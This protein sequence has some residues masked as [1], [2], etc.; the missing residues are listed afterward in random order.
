[1][2]NFGRWFTATK[3]WGLTLNGPYYY[4][5][6][7]MNRPPHRR[8]WTM[9]HDKY[10]NVDTRRH[11]T[12]LS[13][14]QS[15]RRGLVGTAVTTIIWTSVIWLS[16]RSVNPYD[17]MF[18]PSVFFL[19]MMIVL[20]SSINWCWNFRCWSFTT[21]CRP[22][23]S[24]LGWRSSEIKAS[25]NHFFVIKLF[26]NQV[27][28]H[29]VFFLF[30][31]SNRKRGKWSLPLFWQVPPTPLKR[32]ERHRRSQTV[33][34]VAQSTPLLDKIQHSMNKLNLGMLQK[35]K[36]PKIFSPKSFNRKILPKMF[37]NRP[38][39]SKNSQEWPT[40]FKMSSK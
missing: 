4:S 23:V 12:K 17:A 21:W 26:L 37:K 8:S 25:S 33:T 10:S 40:C 20:S 1:M 6:P 29:K 28:N 22:W 13:S 27:R 31:F 34:C 11:I 39:Y 30:N 32:L 2:L 16:I 14:C 3:R 38:K 36:W 35:R 19:Q 18:S 7:T 15:V 5:R 24:P 9:D